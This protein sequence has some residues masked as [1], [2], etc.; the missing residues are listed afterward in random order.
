MIFTPFLSVSDSYSDFALAPLPAHTKSKLFVEEGKSSRSST[1]DIGFYEANT[2]SAGLS[3]I[4]RYFRDAW[5]L[6]LLNENSGT[7]RRHP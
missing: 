5:L 1:T 6:G 4:Q 2:G 7:D 3:G